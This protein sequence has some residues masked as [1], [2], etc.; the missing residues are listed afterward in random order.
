MK[1]LGWT[2]KYKVLDQTINEMPMGPDAD[3]IWGEAV[4]RALDELAAAWK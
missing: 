1:D 4:K 2:K 3:R